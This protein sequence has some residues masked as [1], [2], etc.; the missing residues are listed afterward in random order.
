MTKPLLV[1][2]QHFRKLEELFSPAAYD[3]LSNLCRIEGGRNWPMEQ[4]EIDALL[5][6]ADFYVAARPQLSMEQL[7]RASQLKAVIEVSG[8]F[9]AG[10]DYR[11]CLDRGIEVLSSMPGFRQSVAEMTVAMILSGAR[12]LV[13]QHEAFRTGTEAWLSDREG[14]DFTLFKQSIGFIGYGQI[15]REVHRLLAPFS[16]RVSAYDPWLSQTGTDAELVGLDHLME[17]CQVIVVA[18]VP[19]RENENLVSAAQI[20]RAR[21]GALFVLISR[22]HC[23]DFPALMEAIRLRRIKAAIDVFPEE[24]MPGDHSL[25]KQSGVILSPHRAAAV[26]GGRQLIGDMILHDIAAM[27]ENRPERHLKRADPA[28]LQSLIGAQAAIIGEN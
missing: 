3:A 13:D 21:Q 2:N 27:L 8:A 25:R 15:A 22:A 14:Q 1:L 17:T 26:P 19:T 18:A 20:A 5:P 11:T 28:H 24:P 10:L 12:G 6:E 23:V 7:A 4:T 9:H 16:P